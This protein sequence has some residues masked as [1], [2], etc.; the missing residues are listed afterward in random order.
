IPFLLKRHVTGVGKG[1]LAVIIQASADV[2]RMAVGKNDRVDLVRLNPFGSKKG[3]Q[4]SRNRPHAIHSY[5]RIYQYSLSSGVDE[6]ANIWKIDFLRVLTALAQQGFVLLLGQVRQKHSN[7]VTRSVIHD[8][9]ARKASQ[10]EAKGLGLHTY[11]SC[12]CEIPTRRMSLCRRGSLCNLSILASAARQRGSQVH[13]S[14]HPVSRHV[15]ARSISPMPAIMAAT[16]TWHR[17]FRRPSCSS[18][19]TTLR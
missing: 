19:C 5:P 3:K 6:E 14:S 18:S 11:S 17:Y 8:G 4:F 2:V 7:G 16:T 9:E 1:R 13:R 10:L 15:S 12:H